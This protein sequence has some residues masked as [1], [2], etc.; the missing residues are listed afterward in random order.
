[1]SATR[2]NSTRYPR[3]VLPLAVL[4]AIAIVAVAFPFKTLWR[5]QVALNAASTQISQINRQS[6]ALIQQAKSVSTNAAAIAL[7]REQYQLVQPGQRLIQVLPG[8]GSGYVAQNSTDPG[9]QP[10]VN[11]TSGIV[12]TSSSGSATTSSSAPSGLHG[13]VSRFVGTLEF[14][15]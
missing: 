3:W 14:W 13:F 8:N 15:R 7:A 10:L 11:P 1:M 2:S 5:Q 9:F 6:A 12:P 4:A